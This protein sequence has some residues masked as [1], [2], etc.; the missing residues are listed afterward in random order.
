MRNWRAVEIPFRQGEEK[1]LY[2]ALGKRRLKKLTK[3]VDLT[4]TEVKKTRKNI[5][6]VIKK[7]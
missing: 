4:V 6:L 2:L 5:W 1:R 7:D 3:E